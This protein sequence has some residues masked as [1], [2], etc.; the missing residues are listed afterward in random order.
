MHSLKTRLICVAA[1]LLAAAVIAPAAQA[2][3]AVRNDNPAFLEVWTNN[4]ENLMI[5]DASPAECVGDWDDIYYFMMFN[6]TY[7]PDVYFVQQVT[8]QA[9]LQTIADRMSEIS[10][11]DYRAEVIADPSPA[12]EMN[13]PC[14][15]KHFQTN[16][17]IFREGR[18]STRGVQKTWQAQHLVSGACTNNTQDRTKAVAI[19]IFD[20]IAGKWVDLASIHWPTD[21][22]NGPQ[23]ALS[24]ETEVRNE[25]NET[26]WDAS[27]KIWGGDTNINN[28]VTAGSSS[29]DYNTWYKSMNGDIGLNGVN[30]YFR[31]VSYDGCRRAFPTNIKGCLVLFGPTFGNKQYDYIMASRQSSARPLTNTWV[32]LAESSAG[33]A[34]AA[35]QAGDNG[36]DHYSDHLAVGARIY[37]A[38]G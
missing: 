25:L 38:T 3:T 21:T 13:V 34:A 22:L 11:F 8:N 28:L 24:N 30:S 9:Q 2:G 7:A 37:Y 32:T 10:G 15:R 12:N 17:I 23:C 31:D 6:R 16:G 36:S 20:Q 29:S 1:A 19:R 4:V 14:P 18:F 26:G 33:D 35:H 5:P 27:L